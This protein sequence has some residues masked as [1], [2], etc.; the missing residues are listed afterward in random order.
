MNKK[1]LLFVYT[2]LNLG[3][4]LF[5]YILSKKYPDIDFYMQ[6]KDEDY[7]K[8]FENFK[9]V[10]FINQDRLVDNID[11]DFFDGYIY[12]GGSIFIES[13]YSFGELREFNK[14]I[15]KC[16]ERNKKFFYMSCN[17]GPYQTEEYLELAKKNFELCDGICF[18]DKKS[19]ELFKNMPN[20]FYGPDVVFDLGLD[21][22]E[23]QRKSVGISVIDLSIR[24]SLKDKQPEYEDFIIRIIKKFTKRGYKVYLFSFCEF[25]KDEYAINRILK[26]VPSSDKEKIRV[27]NYKNNIE[28]FIQTYS[29]MKYMVATRFHSMILSM[30]C[31]QK[32]YNLTYSTK[33]NNV[34]ED[35]NLFKKVENI[36]DLSIHTQIKKF[37]FKKVRRYKLKK[38]KEQ[39]KEQ[40]KF[41]KQIKET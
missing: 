4:N 9:N 41:L 23:K 24:D 6:S 7:K 18:R 16:K 8:A 38:I 12:I 35:L 22:K 36:K 32:I 33:Q 1:I 10:K 5:V 21:F 25:E 40:F 19:Y 28:E 14:F 26:K 37:E 34:I 15:K 13:G 31:H 30:I 29:S 17:F 27:V 3:D 20:V 11:I 39:T 2:K